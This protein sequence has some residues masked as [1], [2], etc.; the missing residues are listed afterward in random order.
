MAP[1]KTVIAVREDLPQSYTLGE[2]DFASEA[3]SY[4]TAQAKDV[5][6]PC[7]MLEI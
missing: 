7:G 1:H 2:T 5:L 6:W 4:S 3:N